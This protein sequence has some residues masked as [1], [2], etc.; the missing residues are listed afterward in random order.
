MVVD[1]LFSCKCGSFVL[2]ALAGFTITN[3]ILFYNY[4]AGGFFNSGRAG[5]VGTTAV[6]ARYRFLD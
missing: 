1:M 4:E 2:P 3:K 6:F 5:S